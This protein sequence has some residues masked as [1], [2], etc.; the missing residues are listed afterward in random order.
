MLEKRPSRRLVR[1][2]RINIVPA[3]IIRFSRKSDGTS[4]IACEREDGSTTWER[5]KF[6]FFPLHDLTHFA[7]ESTLGF[8]HGFYG[9]LVN[10]WQI[11]D[12][13]DVKLPPNISEEAI[14][15]E[16]IVSLLD[17]EMG[18]GIRM[19]AEEFSE[20]LNAALSGL[21]SPVRREIS[22]EELNVIREMRLELFGKW[23]N[24]N[25][26]DSLELRIDF[27]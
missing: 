7:V 10:G 8:R 21:E 15:V 24:T 6:D 2:R 5:R 20:A 17:Q 4:V 18:T 1:E 26:G 14:L 27:A 3:L 22:R 9:L 16:S 25:S 13:G 12:F 19:E 23:A 11:T